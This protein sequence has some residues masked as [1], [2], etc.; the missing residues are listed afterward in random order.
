MNFY[1]WVM[2][3][4]LNF[5]G[6]PDHDPAFVDICALQ[7]LRPVF[8]NIAVRYILNL[9]ALHKGPW[10]MWIS[11]V[12][13][14]WNTPII[15]NTRQRDIFWMVCTWDVCQCVTLAAIF[16]LN[17]WTRPLRMMILVSRLAFLWSRNSMVLFIF[18][19]DLVLTIQGYDLC[20][21]F[22]V[23]PIAKEV[24]LFFQQH[25]FCCGCVCTSFC[26]FV[27]LPVSNI[28]KKFFFIII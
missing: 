11:K 28:I 4:W 2:R 21:V 20:K 23:T 15:I 19:T 13:P 14:T 25:S 16:D 3:T 6:N 1:E 18:T 22:F 26:L 8:S 27:C 12:L 17:F 7:L 24:S 10:R 5:G 9:T